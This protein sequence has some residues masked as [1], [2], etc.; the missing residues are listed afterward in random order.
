MKPTIRTARVYVRSDRAPAWVVLAMLVTVITLIAA[1][2]R[3]LWWTATILMNH[4][5]PL[6]IK[7]AVIMVVGVV[8]PPL[9]IIHGV[10]LWFH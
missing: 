8:V 2:I 3:H 4:N 6:I 7:Q 9:G 1:Y 5:D 10:W